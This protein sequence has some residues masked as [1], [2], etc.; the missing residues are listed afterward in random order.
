[1]TGI[2]SRAR[3]RNNSAQF[4]LSTHDFALVSAH[5][6]VELAPMSMD[7][8]DEGNERSPITDSTWK[9]R[10][11]FQEDTSIPVY[12]MYPN[13]SGRTFFDAISVLVLLYDA[14]SIP[15]VLAWGDPVNNPWWDAGTWATVAF[16]SGDVILTFFTG[17][18]AN[19]D[20]ELRWTKIVR[21]YLRTWFFIDLGINCCDWLSIIIDQFL[22]AAEKNSN[23]RFIKLLRVFKLA[24]IVRILERFENIGQWFTSSD[25]FYMLMQVVKLFWFILWINHVLCCAWYTLGTQ[26]G[27]TK[28]TWLDTPLLDNGLEITFE[29]TS[30]HYQY[31][32]S[33]HWSMSQ[34]TPGSMPIG[35]MNTMERA[36]NVFCL[37]FGL[38]FGTSLI[39][40]LSAKIV[41]FNLAKQEQTVRMVQLRRF[42]RE[43]GIAG[44]LAIQIQR[45]IKDR[46]RDRKRLA[47]HEVLV[48]DKLSAGLKAEMSE[49]AFAHLFLQHCI[50]Q[51]WDK[52]D[53][54]KRVTQALCT[55]TLQVKYHSAGDEIFASETAGDSACF[56]ISGVLLYTRQVISNE[57]AEGYTVKKYLVQ[58][59]Y[60]VSEAALW[61]SKDAGH[62][63][64]PWIHKGT[65]LAHKHCEL[66]EVPS[67]DLRSLLWRRHKFVYEIYEQTTIAFSR[68]LHGAHPAE[69][70]TL[71]DIDLGVDHGVLLISFPKSL[72]IEIAD[73]VLDSLRKVKTLSKALGHGKDMTDLRTEVTDGRCAL[74]WDRFGNPERTVLVVAIRISR[75]EDGK[76]FVQLGKITEGLRK[77]EICLPGTKLKVG[78]RPKHGVQRF[79]EDDISHFA[80]GLDVESIQRL[81]EVKMSESYAGLRTKYVRTVFWAKT[82]PHLPAFLADDGSWNASMDPVEFTTGIKSCSKSSPSPA[83]RRSSVSSESPGYGP[84]QE[85][86]ITNKKGN[87]TIFGWMHPRDFDKRTAAPDRESR[88]ASANSIK[89][90]ESN[91][92]LAARSSL[93]GSKGGR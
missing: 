8:V 14:V 26:P 29:T 59:N 30:V 1:M 21:H 88:F 65:M 56:V 81:C 82:M 85:V 69:L 2:S 91:K 63:F 3:Q 92:S 31:M 20:V 12:I 32:T 43:W 75:P 38:L 68:H 27:D 71:S 16:W 72:K 24:R 66:L 73:E 54:D 11:M 87:R 89:Y 19:G 15:V 64:Y 58:A 23:L 83:A 49:K 47:M 42:L 25:Y 13:S 55:R 28:V 36:F 39:S 9:R 52:M 18:Y 46:M 74:G 93:F 35:P 4:S 67:E 61:M 5:D 78:E 76:I 80:D 37:L 48:L 60:W 77:D 41:Q 84:V 10:A 45:Q 40:Q 79:I 70:E 7:S 53:P 50:F 90:T 6:E 57:P 62:E 22:A 51:I 34:M 17:F 86:C 44:S 33:L